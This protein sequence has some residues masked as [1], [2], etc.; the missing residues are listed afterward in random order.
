V[1]CDGG[2]REGRND[3]ASKTICSEIRQLALGDNLL[4]P[5]LRP[6]A[7]ENMIGRVDRRLIQPAA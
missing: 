7:V 6:V 5:R 4:E 1:D 3:E 2:A